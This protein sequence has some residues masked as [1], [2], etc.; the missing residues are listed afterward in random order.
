MLYRWA[1]NICFFFL[2]FFAFGLG[3]L[4]AQMNPFI[5]IDVE[6]GLSQNTVNCILQDSQGYLWI[7]TQNGLNRFDGYDVHIFVNNPDDPASLSNN[8]IR[9]LYE[10]SEGALWVGTEGGGLNRFDRR[11][12]SFERYRYNSPNP[13][14]IS[15]DYVYALL[16]DRNKR[17][18]IGTLGGGLNEMDRGKGTFQHY[19]HDPAN[20]TSISS[21]S[22]KEL[23]EDQ[24]GNFWIGTGS[25]GHGINK[26]DREKGT[27]S[28]VLNDPE[29]FQELDCSSIN[30]MIEDKTGALWIGTWDEGIVW[31]YPPE[32]KT[33]RL[34]KENSPLI[35]NIVRSL[36]CDS[37]GDV[38]I[39][40]WTRGL[41]HWPLNNQS[42]DTYYRKG[43]FENIQTEQF[44]YQ[45]DRENSLRNNSIRFITEDH[46]GMLWIGMNN[47]GVQGLNM[48]P[49]PFISVPSDL[50][51]LKS[52]DNFNA[53]ALAEESPSQIWMGFR[54]GGLVRWNPTTGDMQ[55]HL[56]QPHEPNSPVNNNILSLQY[57][58]AGYLWIGT[59]GG[60]LDRYHLK[61]GHYRHY[62]HDVSDP[63]SLGNDAVHALY[64]DHE[65]T[66]WVGTWEGGLNRYDPDS[67]S[68]IRYNVDEQTLGRNV[69]NEIFEDNQHRLWVG[70]S[71]RGPMV[72]NRETSTFQ[73]YPI[74]KDTLNL[75]SSYITSIIQTNDGSIWFGTGGNGLICYDE[76][77][78]RYTL[79][80][81]EN[82]LPHNTIAAIQQDKS[83]SLWI[84]TELG[85]SKLNIE[86]G[87]FTNFDK[88]DG[89]SSNVFNMGA[90]CQTSTN[91][92]FFGG[93][94]GVTYFDPD[95]IVLDDAVPPVVI[96]Q[97]SL[98]NQPVEVGKSYDDYVILPSP[99][100]QLESIQVSH[101]H[102]VLSFEF[103]ALN[104]VMP[105]KNQ[106]AY[107]LT[108]FETQ[109]NYTSADRR[110]ATYTN[111]QPGKY[112]LEVKG[113]NSDGIW[114]DKGTHLFIEVVPPFWQR[115]WFRIATVLFVIFVFVLLYKVRTQS[116]KKRNEKLESLVEERSHKLEAAQKQLLLQERMAA[117]GQII[118]TVAHEVRN[119]LGTIRA[120]VFSIGEARKKNDDERLKRAL[121]LAERNVS[122]CD[123]I[124]SELLD[125]TRNRE[126]HLKKVDLDTWL[127][128]LLS[129]L[130][131][132]ETIQ[133]ETTF[134]SEMLITVDTED[135]RRAIIN[136]VENA[137]QAMDGQSSHD[138]VHERRIH[139]STKTEDGRV[140]I[141][142]QDTGPGIHEE[143]LE[144]IFEPLYSTKPYGIGLGLPIVRKIM[145]QHRGG[146]EIQS[147]WGSGTI[148][149]LWLPL[150]DNN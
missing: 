55:L 50:T 107:R 134:K 42:L 103:A 21:N 39:G 72:L 86:N 114:N 65:N 105:F 136:V 113:S 11:T 41:Q 62:R 19:L 22:I 35:D 5:S 67:D 60:G 99:I 66:L 91:M 64:L 51:R 49:K 93:I 37:S 82:G 29:D 102:V 57:D 73:A 77:G 94:D 110:F 18:W 30:T 13:S 53:F 59:D 85:L 80:T 139:I 100:S 116:L 74:G 16:E 56:H 61:T 4:Q 121:S 24:W 150:S 101:K 32:G 146:F 6:R 109:W 122:R 81:K 33:I 115:I 133:V 63:A 76:G 14:S 54:G 78:N 10:D 148:A 43:R 130:E 2:Y 98:F 104:F 119:P 75:R 97:L 58:P 28:H 111:L 144:K 3:I 89:L 79:F 83:G 20:L 25:G 143:E 108:G 135:V 47:G 68:F 27:F 44:Y 12:E 88:T 36:Y 147:Q 15:S 137:I 132:P 127:K 31:H 112:E 96:T 34:L 142:I 17:F 38:W 95:Q 26:F 71:R 131:V 84:S 87:I 129:E 149:V 138:G 46:C 23:V 126:L 118:A 92:L 140:L 120:S 106:Y 70:T 9:V 45:A 69:A 128:R 52:I 145:K 124:I 8:I 117:L 7:G 141:S 40:T 1:Q 123:N 90:V 125:F 48:N